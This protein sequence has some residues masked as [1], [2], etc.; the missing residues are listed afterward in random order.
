MVG[1]VISTSSEF[2]WGTVLCLATL[3]HCL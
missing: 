3:T 1:D 2:Q